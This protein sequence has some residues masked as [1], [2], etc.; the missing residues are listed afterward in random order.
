MRG[1][2]SEDLLDTYHAERHPV[3]AAVLR[4]VQT[5]SLLMDWVGARDPEVLAAKELFADLTRLPEV[6]RHLG[7]LLSGLAIRYPI[8]GSEDHPL[9]GRSAPDLDL[10]PIRTHELLRSGRGVL[11]DPADGFAKVAGPWSDRVDRTGQG[12]DTEPMLVR[13][14]GYVCWAGAPDDLEA[15]LGRWFGPPR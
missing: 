12:A 13:P 10:G 7:D 9:V 2:A 11:L 14:D 6:Q 1:W 5:Q 8:P 3:G 4:N 15:A